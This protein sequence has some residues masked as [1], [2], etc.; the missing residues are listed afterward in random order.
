MSDKILGFIGAGNMAGA[1]INGIVGTKTFPA[2]RIFVYDINKD[3]CEA[4]EQKTGIQVI[5]SIEQLTEKC[6]I[7]FLAVKPQNFAEVLASVKPAVDEKTLFVSIAAGISTKYIIGHQ[8]NAQYAA[9]DRKGR[10]ST[11][12]DRKRGGRGFSAG[13]VFIW[14]L[15]DGDCS[16]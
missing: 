8:N 6:D 5:S 10:Y 7:I 13:C 15:R 1:I 3:K 4:L 11:E 12:P 16:G 14:R 2:K 9:F